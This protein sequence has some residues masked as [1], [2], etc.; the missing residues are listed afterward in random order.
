HSGALRLMLPNLSFKNESC[1]ACIFGKHC[2][3][4]FSKFMT[5]YEN[6]FDLIHSN[7]WTA[8]CASMANHKYFVTFI[9]EKS[10]YTRL[11]LIQGIYRVID[12]FVNFQTYETNQFNSKIK[13]FR[14][15]NRREYTS[16]TFKQRLAKH[17]I[18]HQTN[19]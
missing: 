7:V 11:T 19:C 5:I 3:P 9:Y 6:C 14:S 13:I 2:K 16:H 17:G 18:I 8:P 15:D 4:V 12:A 10:K 1:E